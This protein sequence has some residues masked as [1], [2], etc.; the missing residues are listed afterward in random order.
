M[1]QLTVVLEAGCIVLEEV[2]SAEKLVLHLTSP[3]TG[4]FIACLFNIFVRYATL[5]SVSISDKV[6][7]YDWLFKKK[8]RSGILN[9]IFKEL[10]K[11]EF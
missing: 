5:I 4:R 6:I 10:F 2:G 3:L 11:K 7:F 8:T 1:V 9:E